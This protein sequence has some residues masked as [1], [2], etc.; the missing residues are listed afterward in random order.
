ML[1]TVYA[2]SPVVLA[3]DEETTLREAEACARRAFELNP[4]R[5]RVY[6]SWVRSPTAVATRGKPF[7]C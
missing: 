6:R 3:G 5:R 1:G 2:W 7:G 4:A